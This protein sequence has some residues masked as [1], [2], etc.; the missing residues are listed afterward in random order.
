MRQH[1]KGVFVLEKR[2]LKRSHLIYYIPVFDI[3]NTKPDRLLGYL[4]DIHTEGM[5][6][7]GEVPLKVGDA[8]S[9]KIDAS[10]LAE[11]MR[12]IVTE[13]VVQW[14]SK[15]LNPDYYDTGIAFTDL[16]GDAILQIDAIIK[17]FGF[18]D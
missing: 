17:I 11:S 16:S 18:Q 5:K 7:M 4:V 3:Y 6:L 8:L 1:R 2:R 10:R 12:P 15:S 13:G 9:L 14:Q